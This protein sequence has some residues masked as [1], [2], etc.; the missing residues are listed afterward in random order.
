MTVFGVDIASYQAGLDLSGLAGIDFVIAKATESDSYANPH[1]AGWQAAAPRA[2]K[3]F[4]WYHFLSS[5]SGS[6]AQA[7][8]TARHVDAA[9][10]G[11]VDVEATGGSTPRLPDLV[12]YLDAAEAAGLRIRLV[13]LPRWYWQRI[14]SPDLSPVTARGIGIVS[15]HYPVT[16][17]TGTAQAYAAAGGDTGVGWRPYGNATPLIWQ[18]TD[19][20]P[21]GGQKV[22]ADAY[23]GSREQLAAFLAGG[24]ARSDLTEPRHSHPL[25]RRPGG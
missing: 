5:T 10:P 2:G 3:L 13:Y 18:F 11:M 23:R 8:W 7:A 6:A 14:G 4:A 19:A 12:G 17:P 9:L 25:I 1:Y 15:S 16:A 22:D 20:A 24:A 21:E